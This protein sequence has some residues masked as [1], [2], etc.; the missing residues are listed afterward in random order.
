MRKITSKILVI[1]YFYFYVQFSIHVK[2]VLKN[3][4]FWQFFDFRFAKIFGV[5]KF[6]KIYIFK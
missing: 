4:D 1:F 2:K 3:G 5:E 6:V